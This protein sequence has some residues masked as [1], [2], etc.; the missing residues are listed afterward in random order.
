VGKKAYKYSAFGSF[1]EQNQNG[2]TILAPLREQF[3]SP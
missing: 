1:G 3:R 2:G